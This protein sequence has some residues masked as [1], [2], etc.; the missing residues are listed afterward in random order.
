MKWNLITTC[1]MGAFAR[2]AGAQ[3]SMPPTRVRAFPKYMS[4]Q[5]VTNVAPIYPAQAKQENVQGTVALRLG[6]ARRGR[7]ST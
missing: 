1:L 4:T 7:W 2:V 6:S 3:V 5:V